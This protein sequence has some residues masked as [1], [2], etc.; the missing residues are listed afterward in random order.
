MARSFSSVR[1][2]TLLEL[3]TVISIIAVL[4]ALLIAGM[5]RSL[6]TADRA[7]CSANLR[8]VSV[9]II[10]YAGDHDQALPPSGPGTASRSI[11][12]WRANLSNLGYIPIT[13]TN[14]SGPIYNK[15]LGCPARRKR[16][17]LPPNTMT[18]AINA[19]LCPSEDEIKKVLAAEQPSRTMIVADAPAPTPDDAITSKS[20]RSTMYENNGGKAWAPGCEH[21]ERANIL[22]LDG[23][24]ESR[25]WEEIPATTSWSKYDSDERLF[26]R[27]T[28]K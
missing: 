24:V 22:F 28:R 2:F 12:S 1:A 18:Y 20:T 9:A 26:W 14:A 8:T 17:Q 6:G 16:S 25:L 19:T 23:H 27:G 4:A 10:S 7:T 21:S 5:R 11:A 3:V 13:G 15:V